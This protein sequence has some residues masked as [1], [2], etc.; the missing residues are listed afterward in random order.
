[1]GEKD[2]EIYSSFAINFLSHLSEIY[3]IPMFHFIKEN[4]VNEK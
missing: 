3:W 2:R 1:M 4:K